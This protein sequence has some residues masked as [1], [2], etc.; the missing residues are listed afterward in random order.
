MAEPLRIKAQVLAAMPQHGPDSAM[1]CLT[2]ALRRNLHSH[3]S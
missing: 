2:E 3:W 1:N